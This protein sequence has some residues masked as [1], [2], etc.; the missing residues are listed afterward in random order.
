M[1][2]QLTATDIACRRGDRLLFRGLSL[3]LGAGEALHVTGANGVGKSSLMRILA[4]LLR[5]FAG[6]VR[7]TGAIGLVDERLPLD[8]N[9]TLEKALSFWRRLDRACEMGDTLDTVQLNPLLEVPVRYLSTG[10][11]KRAS[12]ALLLLRDC[13]IWLLDEPLS[14]LD[15]GAQETVARLIAR[16]CE[17]GGL[18]VIASHQPLGIA[19]IATLAVEDYAQ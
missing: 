13:P 8:P 9:A 12:L 7:A 6:E 1:Q 18:A 4:G 3:S 17:K 15:T 16:H 19:E 10:Q 5:P 14:G 2:A 11:R